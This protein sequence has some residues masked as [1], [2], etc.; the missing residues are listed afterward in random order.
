[1]KLIEALEIIKQGPPES[2]AFAVDLACG[3]TP[4]HFQT[5]LHAH[6]QRLFP[7]NKVVVRTG[8]FG[9]LLGNL[10][11]IEKDLPGNVVAVVEWEDLDPRLGIRR[12]GGWSPAQ[13]SDIV[14]GVE[15]RAARIAETLERLGRRGVVA[16]SLP[17]LPLPP[18]A[19][20]PGWQAGSF[21][22]DLHAVA[23]ALG[24]R[25]SRLTGVR[26]VSAQRL[27]RLS[28]PASRFDV[29]S[30][31]RAGFPYSLPHADTLAGL[32]ASLVRNPLPKKG[33]IT[34][35]DDT[36]WQGILGEV[37]VE[38]IAWDLDHSAQRHGLYQQM[39]VSLGEAGAL[40]AVASKNEPALVEQAFR[41]AGPILSRER[42]FPL[43]ANWGAKSASVARILKA[44]N[45]GA[46]SVVFVENSPLDLAEV[47][48]AHPEIE[49][50]LFP[51]DDDAAT[52]Q[53]L[54]AL[55]DLFGKQSV[56]DE[57]RIRL[58]SL[59]SSRDA[60]E[61]SASQG[62]SPEQFLK[63]ADG[64]LSVSFA[65]LPPDPRALE[66]LNKTNQ[67]NLNGKRH[68]EV[69]WADYRNDPK[70]FLLTASYEDKFGPLGK[71]AV[72]A[73]RV[74]GERLSIDH[75]V[76]S[77]R[78]FS[79]RVEHGCLEHLFRK[80]KTQEAWFDFAATS[81]NGPTQD[82]FRE[83]LGVVPGKG[84]PVSRERFLEACPPIY[85]TIRELSDG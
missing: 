32:V 38:G 52:Y 67:F 54:E 22:S 83:I 51:R 18:A 40:I 57:D 20:V 7:G 80:F 14:H 60:E 19:F 69:S 68:S 59:R 31:L 29:K 1:M 3:F 36:L 4:L 75:W 63:E 16:L 12:L 44:C 33:L 81:R 5:F 37:N 8:L 6:L 78:A 66:L 21:E 74:E 43:E 17:T 2:A 35:L 56:S 24:A 9:D 55:R 46:D 70:V 71:I 15:R 42:V 79:R 84:F 82:F 23:A 45:V 27:Q 64:K 10:E 72:L 50:L 65:K 28:A 34:D 11:R 49:C 25:L 39:L 73:G 76:M 58:S 30:T 41:E 53:L 85:L 47:K 77:C 61:A 26:L 62:G 13:L 48:K